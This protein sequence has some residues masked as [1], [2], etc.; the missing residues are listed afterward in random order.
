MSVDSNALHCSFAPSEKSYRDFGDP[1]VSANLTFRIS[2]ANS[3]QTWPANQGASGRRRH[4]SDFPRRAARSRRP[5]AG[6]LEIGDGA[7]WPS[8]G[9]A[10]VFRERSNSPVVDGLQDVDQTLLDVGF[11]PKVAISRQTIGNVAPKGG[12]KA[13]SSKR[14]RR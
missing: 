12:R 13:K 1:T 14:R 6:N 5:R 11:D 8:A 2:Q 9:S 4:R 7:H 10:F 3:C